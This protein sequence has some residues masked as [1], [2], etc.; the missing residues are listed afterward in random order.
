[1][2]MV[3]TSDETQ[4]KFLHINQCHMQNATQIR[5]M[6]D[7]TFQKLVFIYNFIYFNYLQFNG[8]P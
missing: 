2:Q 5:L 8:K 3:M 4:S 7:S 6:S 1:M